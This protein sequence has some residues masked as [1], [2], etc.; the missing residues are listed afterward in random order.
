MIRHKITK[1]AME[2]I[3]ERFPTLNVVNDIDLLIYNGKCVFSE[4]NKKE[5]SYGNILVVTRDHY[6][7]TVID[8][9]KNK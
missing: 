4:D 5:Y 2:R 7:V 9:L 8:R 6:I 1:H 3:R